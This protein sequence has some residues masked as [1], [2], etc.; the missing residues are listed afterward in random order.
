MD[1]VHSASKLSDMAQTSDVMQKYYMQHITD[2][3]EGLCNLV[4]FKDYLLK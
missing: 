3:P 4:I 1:N 2:A